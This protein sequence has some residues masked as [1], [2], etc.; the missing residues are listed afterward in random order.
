M[1]KLLLLCLLVL[2]IGLANAQKRIVVAQDGGGDFKTV[3]QAINAVPNYSKTI[4]QIFIKKGVYKEKLTLTTS[5]TNVQMVGEDVNSTILTYDDYASKKDSAGVNIGTSRSASFHIYGTGFSARNITFENS[6]G[7]VGQALAIYVAGDKSC[8]I[9]CRFLG[10][11]DTIYTHGNGSRQYY[12]NCYIEGTTDFIFG[13]ATAVF[14]ACAVYCKKGGSYITAAS[15]LD[16]TKYGYVLMNCKITGSA[17]ANSYFLGR[18]WRP[19]AKVV[20]LHCDLGNMIKP[21]GWD[22][23]RNPENEKT[24]FYAEYKNTGDGYKPDQRVTW[25]HQLTDAEAEQYNLNQ[26]LKGWNPEL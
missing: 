25:S 19:N 5:K 21:E 18:P 15:T 7:P 4:T 10:N 3:Q 26:I 1:K 23:W 13:A 8:F 20:Y 22:N 17:P 9:N 2:H 24:A 14:N 6:A 12:K 16:T 11:Q